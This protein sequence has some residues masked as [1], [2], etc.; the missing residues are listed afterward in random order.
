MREYNAATA[1]A[2][3]FIKDA[4]PSY[5]RRIHFTGTVEF[6]MRAVMKHRDLDTEEKLLCVSLLSYMDLKTSFAYPSRESL[7]E[8]CS[9]SESTVDRRIR[10]LAA[11][12][13]IGFL[14][15]GYK[16]NNLY[17]FLPHPG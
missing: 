1:D 3:E 2:N 17:W 13:L 11:I 4:E 7:A 14:R 12:G 5:E 6:M 9:I 16:Q 8:E 10:K 15:R